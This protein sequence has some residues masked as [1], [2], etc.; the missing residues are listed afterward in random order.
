MD[1]SR[2]LRMRAKMVEDA[3]VQFIPAEAEYPE[4]IHRAMRYSLLS[5]GKRLRPALV[6]GAAEAVGCQPQRVLPAACALELIH[7]YS[8]VHDDLPAMDND[9]MRRGK[10]TNHKVFGEAIAILAG[11]AMLTLAF[12]LMA[13]NAATSSA[14][15]VVLAI[16]ELAHA[17]G[18]QGLIG[19]QVVDIQS[20]NSLVDEGTMEYIHRHKTG[21]LFRAAVRCG[22]IL[23]G[24][25]ERQLGALTEYAENLGLAFQIVDDILDV[26]GDAAKLGKPVGSDAKNNKSTYPAKYGIEHSKHMARQCMHKGMAALESFGPEV[27][28]LRHT[29]KFIVH[30]DH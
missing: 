21:A 1:F 24:A 25:D 30:R 27:D 22:A 29:L 26:E 18:S 3:M 12:Q 20:A 15:A 4:V 6:L 16:K 7:T 13:Q 10:A 9:D 8:L 23:G 17:A 2:Q 19:G 14:E 11:D 5:G 28:F